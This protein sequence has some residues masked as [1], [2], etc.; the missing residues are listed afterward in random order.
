MKV[1]KKMK[2]DII[3]VSAVLV[4]LGVMMLLC[5]TNID[6]PRNTAVIAIAST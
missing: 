3:F 6:T 4:G 1:V 2:L 5:L